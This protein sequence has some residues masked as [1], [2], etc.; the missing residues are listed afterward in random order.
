[1]PTMNKHVQKWLDLLRAIWNKWVQFLDKYVGFVSGTLLGLLLAFI[2][3]AGLQPRV[4]RAVEK[5]AED[6]RMQSQAA[7]A[8]ALEK[9]RHQKQ[10][11]STKQLPAS[12]S[13]TAP[14]PAVIA[15]TSGPAQNAN[16]AY[17]LQPT[18]FTQLRATPTP[19]SGPSHKVEHALLTTAFLAALLAGAGAWWQY[20]R[21]PQPDVVK[22][23]VLEALLMLKAHQQ[24]QQRL[25]LTPRQIKRFNSKARV[26]H[27]QLRALAK[28]DQE[29]AKSKPLGASPREQ[30]PSFEFPVTSQ[31]QAFQLL[32]LLEENRQQPSK[33]MPID[34]T[35]FIQEIQEAYAHHAELTAARIAAAADSVINELEG[36][37]AIAQFEGLNKQ[38]SMRLLEQLYEMNSGLLG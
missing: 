4:R 19:A 11:P 5:Q 35:N 6:Q 1:M 28:H 10:T 14:K 37:K 30:P 38:V 21:S 23:K 36:K 9:A 17:S 13:V 34:R 16:K 27:S 18:R 2:F 32:L 15:K 8:Q 3:Y 20:R 7:A 33:S 31:L 24:M 22:S 29:Q 25:G 12:Q 26:Q